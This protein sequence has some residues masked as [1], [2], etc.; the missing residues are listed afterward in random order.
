MTGMQ[1]PPP[2]WGE[3]TEWQ[4]PGPPPR[5]PVQPPYAAGY[6]PPLAQPQASW[7][8]TMVPAVQTYMIPAILVTLFCFLPTGIAAIVYA[9]QVS[10]KRSIGD[11]Q[12]AVKASRQ[13]RLWTIVS[14]AVG[15]AAI[16]ILLIASA[17]SSGAG[18][19]S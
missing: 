12:G 6:Q 14:A 17:A 15:V 8:G 2:N 9:S 3:A 13:A 11:Y 19:T 5:G 10:S 16:A 7:P 1:N 4:Q 18:G